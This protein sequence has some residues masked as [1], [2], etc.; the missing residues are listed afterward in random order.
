MK[1]ILVALLVI[2]VM[3]GILFVMFFG[4]SV[5]EARTFNKYL[6]DDKPRATVTDAFF[7]ELRVDACK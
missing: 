5:M 4:K 7:A 3:I 6:S 1:D 2:I